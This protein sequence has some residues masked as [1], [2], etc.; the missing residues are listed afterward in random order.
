[1]AT[2]LLALALS[3]TM[4]WLYFDRD[5]EVAAAVM[6]ATAGDRRSDLGMVAGIVVMAAGV[7]SIV[8][9]PTDAAETAGAWN[10]ATGVAV[11]ILGDAV[12]RHSLGLGPSGRRLVVA[13]LFILTAP[14]EAEAS[15][16][17]QLAAD[18]GLMILLIVTERRSAASESTARG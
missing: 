6:A 16:L 4:W 13:G 11:Y 9:H 5:D 14:L 8:A 2:A 15:G 7:K 1:M 17:A 12:F 3:A 10:L 18:V